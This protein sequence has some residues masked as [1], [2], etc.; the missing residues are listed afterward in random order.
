[1][2]KIAFNIGGSIGD[3]VI[4]TGVLGWLMDTHPQAEFTIAAAPAV[5][6]LFAACPRMER[7]IAVHRRPLRLHWPLLW[8]DLRK[9]HW[10]L[11]VD[12]RSS[13]ISYLVRTRSRKIFYAQ[14]RSLSRA[15]QLARMFALPELPPTRLW[16]DAASE[17]RAQA[18]LPAGRDVILLAPKAAAP[19]KDW[20]MERFAALA[21]RLRK[22]DTVFAMLGTAAQAES[23]RPLLAALPAEQR[24]DLCGKTDLP[25]AFAVMRRAQLFIGNDSGLLHMAAAAGIPCVGLYGVSN[26]K[27]YA[28][29]GPHVRIAKVREFAMDEREL[30]EPA[31]MEQL[32]VDR[33]LA[34]V[35]DVLSVAALHLVV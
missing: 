22:E 5:A 30:S 6:P 10:D 12:L 35:E 19:H 31:I 4:S 7:F 27:M 17:A 28:P 15:A 24:I 21:L 34:A 29:H 13:A 18:L 20:P 26:D 32:T 2:K 14:D 11:V 8:N 9:T 1:M 33:V 16:A 3:A 23:V 25:T